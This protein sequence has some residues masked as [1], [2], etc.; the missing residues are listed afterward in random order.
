[1]A[2]TSNDWLTALLERPEP[3]DDGVRTLDW[4]PDFAEPQEGFVEGLL[5][6]LSEPDGPRPLDTLWD[7]PLVEDALVGLLREALDEGVRE[8]TTEAGRP[9]AGP[10][11][12]PENGPDPLIDPVPEP[13][14]EPDPV[15]EAFEQGKEAGRAEILASQQAIADQKL[16]L[17]QT[18]RALDQAAMDAL[19]DE[20]AETVIALCAQAMADFVPEPDALKQRCLTAANRLGLGAGGGPGTGEATLY[21]HPDD[22]ALLD[23]QGLD[24]WILIGEPS[25]ERGGVRFEAADG[26]VSDRPQDWRRAIAAALKG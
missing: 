26:S 7:D 4:L 11:T 2:T 12:A 3:R 5:T 20:L 10:E 8:K 14:F 16:A 1:M 6:D 15:E 23:R 21:L 25:A 13:A 19:A 18:F 17:R 24:G 22:L 9:E